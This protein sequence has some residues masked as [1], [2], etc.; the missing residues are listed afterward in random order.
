MFLMAVSS[1]SQHRIFSVL[2]P[3]CLEVDLLKAKALL[4]RGRV[5]HM[6]GTKVVDG[7]VWGRFS[8]S[9]LF[10]ATG[11]STLIFQN[12][13]TWHIVRFLTLISHSRWIQRN[14]VLKTNT[15]TVKLIKNNLTSGLR[16]HTSP[17]AF[18][19]FLLAVINFFAI[20]FSLFRVIKER[21]CNHFGDNLLDFRLRNWDLYPKLE[22][23]YKRI[24][25]PYITKEGF[26][27]FTWRQA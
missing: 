9:Q 2:M 10:F 23:A 15:E 21:W 17:R 6:L 12:I 5:G 24:K 22:R 8:D 18:T 4:W 11:F 19:A 26:L 7:L 14:L 20:E 1:T 13:E 3:T 16:I 25:M 27:Y